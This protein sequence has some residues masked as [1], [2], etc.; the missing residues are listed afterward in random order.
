MPV[1][2]G[3]R[4]GESSR[5]NRCGPVSHALYAHFVASVPD[6]FGRYRHD[7][8]TLTDRMFPRRQEEMLPLV[9]VA[10]E[11]YL[12]EG[13]VKVWTVDGVIFGE[14][15][16]FHAT[17]NRYH[18]TPEPPSEAGF[19]G[20]MHTGACVA[21]AL[22]QAKDWGEPAVVMAALRQMH[23]DS[24]PAHRGKGGRYESTTSTVGGPS[25]PPSGHGREH[26][27]P[28]PPSPPSPPTDRTEGQQAGSRLGRGLAALIPD[29]RPGPAANPLMAGRRA[30]FE[31]K[32]LRLVSRKVELTGEEPTQVFRK[33]SGYK[34]RD[35]VMR[36]KTNPAS[37]SDDRLLQTIA[38][39]EA[40]IA[41]L[42]KAARVG[43]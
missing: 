18:R 15:Y 32:C 4:A 16:G 21:T 1:V 36:Y 3:D 38:D 14:L 9:R 10:L 17:G 42:E 33:A 26:R 23:A 34:D 6:D 22:G 5:L 41:D 27:V 39:L 19:P 35:G 2:R 11:E 24:R 7:A 12:R 37:L 31:S 28:S 13:L 29:S 20:H 8:W 40:D 43:A 30:E 25:E